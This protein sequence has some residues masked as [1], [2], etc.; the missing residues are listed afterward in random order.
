MNSYFYSGGPIKGGSSRIFW[1][2][3]P[4]PAVAVAGLGDASSWS[5]LDEINGVKENVRVAAAGNENFEKE[6]SSNTEIIFFH[7]FLLASWCQ[8]TLIGKSYQH[9]R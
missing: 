6:K 3:G 7:F 1:G 4:F 2:I 8:G 9:I 5:E